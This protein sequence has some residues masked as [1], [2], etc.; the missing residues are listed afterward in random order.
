M[1]VPAVV[2]LTYAS[3]VQELLET[4][5]VVVVFHSSS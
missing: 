4:G 1:H 3:L 5:V 2:G